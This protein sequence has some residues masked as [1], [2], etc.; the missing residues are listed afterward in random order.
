MIANAFLEAEIDRL[1]AA[2]SSGFARG[3]VPLKG[4]EEEVQT[5]KG[6]R[7]IPSARLIAEASLWH[8]CASPGAVP[9]SVRMEWESNV[10]GYGHGGLPAN[11]G[12]VA[13]KRA[14]NL[15]VGEFSDAVVLKTASMR[16]LFAFVCV[17]MV[18]SIA[19]RRARRPAC[20][21]VLP[22]RF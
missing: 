3:K 16:S 5:A 9:S 12:A 14:G 21:Q 4:P 11:A 7:D 15:N 17:A 1:S 20:A 2:V 13:F 6:S 10:I 22:F 19:L 18:L 8:S